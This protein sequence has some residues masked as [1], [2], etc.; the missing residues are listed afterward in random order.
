MAPASNPT[1]D[2]SSVGRLAGIKPG[3]IR[4]TLNKYQLR[5]LIQRQLNAFHRD[6]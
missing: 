3:L 2:G 6:G 5:Q 4:T 1:F